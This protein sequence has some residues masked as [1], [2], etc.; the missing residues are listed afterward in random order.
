MAAGG[1]FFAMLAL[2]ASGGTPTGM[3]YEVASE[4]LRH[5]DVDSTHRSRFEAVLEWMRSEEMADGS[6]DCASVR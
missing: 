3:E 1:T 5:P 2:H 6:F 4:A